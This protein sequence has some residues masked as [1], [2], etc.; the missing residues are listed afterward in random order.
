MLRAKGFMNKKKGLHTH[1]DTY[2]NFPQ[3]ATEDLCGCE[4]YLLLVLR[5]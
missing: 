4:L 2:K 1:T 3:W 5:K